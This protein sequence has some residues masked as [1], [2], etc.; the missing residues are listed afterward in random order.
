MAEALKEKPGLDLF[1]PDHL[2]N[3][4]TDIPL[5]WQVIH[6]C[7][8]TEMEGGEFSEMLLGDSPETSC[9]KEATTALQQAITD[10]FLQVGRPDL[11]RM[12]V[13]LANAQ[14]QIW[15]MSLEKVEKATPLIQKA[16]DRQSEMVDAQLEKLGRESTDLP[17]LSGSTTSDT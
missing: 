10:F 11:A 3:L 2:N 14:N 1:N 4:Y 8:D 5:I 17:E 13:E 9:F 6:A 16:L 7:C 15:Q 12:T